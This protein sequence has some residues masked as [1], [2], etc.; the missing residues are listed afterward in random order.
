[1]I[2][3]EENASDRFYLEQEEPARSCLLALRQLIL[4]QDALLT[5]AWK[6]GM[7]FFCY[8]NKMC[9]YLWL[10]KITGQPYLGVVEGKR[11]VHPQLVQ[12]KRSRMKVIRFD[13]HRDLPVKTITAILQQ[14]LELYRSGNVKT[15]P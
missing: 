3:G 11:I 15:K 13:P 8:K 1:M 10:D 9:C 2:P 14:M 7:P 12:E 6:Y 5:P 4:K